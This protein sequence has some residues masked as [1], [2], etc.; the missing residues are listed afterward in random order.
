MKNGQ[1]RNTGDIGHTNA[2]HMTKT[3]KKINKNNKTHN[4]Q[5]RKIN[6]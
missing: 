2:R 4:T 5:H 6:G 1:L 3:M